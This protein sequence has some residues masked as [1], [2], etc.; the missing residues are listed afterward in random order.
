M[1]SGRLVLAFLV[2][3]SSAG[4]PLAQVSPASAP[5][6]EA[7]SR[8]LL[9]KYCVT[10]HNDRLKTAGLSLQSLQ[11]DRVAQ[12]GEVWERVVR[13]LHAGMMPPADVPR[14]PAAAAESVVSF[15]ETTLDRAAGARPN[16]GPALIH[17][18]NRAEYANSIR[19][20]L[21]LDV[22]VASLLPPDDSIAGFDN[23]AAALGSSP[24][25]LERYLSA[26]MKI[27]PLAV[28]IY[29]GG[30]V[31]TTYRAPGA[32]TQIR[33]VEGLPFG[34]R[35]G[36]LIEHTF[37][38]DGEYIVAPTL[39]RNNVGKVRGLEDEHQLQILVDD[40]EVHRVAVGTREQYL[41]SISDRTNAA[42][43]PAFDASLRVRVPV[44]AGK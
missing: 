13:K 4:T 3:L 18:V 5:A 24:V 37:P 32:S 8:A 34:T 28:G 41:A 27:A 36:L 12:D 44:K 11:M 6:A 26:A 35:G 43:A 39:W 22:D 1:D 21:G 15:L 38:V 19:D 42:V 7:S 17:R 2:V 40:A 20:L 14:P 16:P 33:H 31:A 23:I 10:C 30:P 29:R 25:L 9:D